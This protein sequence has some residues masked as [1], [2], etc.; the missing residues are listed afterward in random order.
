MDDIV[1]SAP[2]TTG[3]SPYVSNVVADPVGTTTATLTATRQ[4]FC[5]VFPT[6]HFR[7]R[8]KGT[9]TWTTRAAD[10]QRRYLNLT[11]LTPATTYE[12]DVS[13][14]ETYAHPFRIEFRTLP[15]APD[16]LVPRLLAINLEDVVRTSVTAVAEVA[17]KEADTSVHLLY[18]NL[19]SA[20]FSTRQSAPVTNTEARFPLSG[21][22][23]G[24]RYRLW[25]SLDQSLLTDT[26]TPA[27]KPDDVLSAEFTTIPPGVLGVAPRATGQTTA[28]LTVAIA[29]PNGQ[30]QTVYSQYRTASPLGST[31]QPSDWVDIG[32][33]PV[34]DG[35]TATVDITDLMSDTEYEARVSLDDTFPD[36]PVDATK[37]SPRFR[38]LPPGVDRLWVKEVGETTATI[39]IT[40]TLP[41]GQ[42]TLYLIYGPIDGDW[43]ASLEQDLQ[44][45]QGDLN[46]QAT[47]EI[48]LT[49]LVSG[50]EYEV[51]ISYDARLKNAVGT[52]VSSSQTRSAQRS[53]PK[54]GPGTSVKEEEEV[55][56]W[57]TGFATNP[58]PAVS[59][60]EV[61]DSGT[62][63]ITKTSA[64]ARVHVTNPDGTAE[65]HIRYSTDS[66][67]DDQNSTIFTDKAAP[68]TSATYFDFMLD[69]LTS[70]TTYYV[71]TSYDN[72]YPAST[73]TKST[74]FTT[75]PPI[76]TE[77]AAADIDQT[78]ATVTVTVDE[79]NDDSV[80]LHIKA[81]GLAWTTI[82]P[83]DANDPHTVVF[84][85]NAGT[86]TF[87]L[88]GL[89]AGTKYD[90]Y[91]SY[92]STAPSPLVELADLPPD[93][94]ATF[95]T[96]DATITEVAAADIDQTSA[97]VTVTVQT[98]TTKAV[99]LHYGKT[100]AL[101]STWSGPK[102]KVVALDTDTNTYTA[103]FALDMLTSGT[104]YTV[105]ASYESTPPASGTPLAPDQTDTFTTDPPSVDKV[106]VTD[107]TDTTAQVTVTIAAPNG[108]TQ[109][110]SVRYQTTPSGNW[111]TIQPDPTTDTATAVVDLTQLTANTQYR[112]EATLVGDSNQVVRFATFSTLSAGPSVSTVAMKDDSISQ[113]EA[114]AVVSIAKA[115][116]ASK[117]VR[118]HYRTISPEGLWETPT[119]ETTDTT[120][121]SVEID[122]AD[123]KSGTEYYVEA[124]LAGAFDEGVQST[125]FTTLP[126]K[127][128][129]VNVIDETPTTAKIR[130]AV[131]EPNGKTTLFLRYGSSGN[132]R[133]D[134]A[135]KVSSTEVGF[136]LIGL[137]PNSTYTVQ[138]S[139]DS[140]FPS[141]AT[142]TATANT[143]HL[144][145]PTVAVPT[146]T[147]TTAMVEMTVS[148]SSDQGGVVYHRHR[149]TPSGAWSTIRAA[150][151]TAGSATATLSGLTSDTEHTV[152]ASLSRSF[153]DNA[154]G[155]FTFTTDPPSVDRVEVTDKTETTAEIT[156]T[157][158]APNGDSQTVHLDYDTTSNTEQ[159]T[160]GS[161]A[162]PKSSSDG[163]ATID[164]SGLS[165]GTQYTV[166]ASLTQDFSGP[167]R[168][169]TFTTTS[170]DPDV[171]SVEVPDAT[172]T[173]ISATATITVANPGTVARTVHLRYQTADPVGAWI[174][175]QPSPAT[176]VAV[177]GTA[178]GELTPL[179]SG[180]QYKV[181]ASLDST[182]TSGVQSATFTTKAPIVSTV[183]VGGETRSTATVKV[184]VLN[185]NGQPVYLQYRTGNGDWIGRFANVDSEESSVDIGLSGL[186]SGT[187]YT[188]Q[189]SYD[190]T[191]ETGVQSAPFSTLA[192]PAPPPSRPNRPTSG[193][194]GTSSGGGTNQSPEFLDG[195]RAARS[196]EENTPAGV[197]VG[198]PIL[199]S[200]PDDDELTY[201]LGGVD[202]GRFDI[203][204]DSGQLL[205]RSALDYET[206]TIYNVTVAVSDGKDS[207]G[208]ENTG[209]D[210]SITVTILVTDQDESSPPSHPS[211]FGEGSRTVRSV[212]E[213]APAGVNV[214]NPILASDPDDD[215][216]TYSLGGVD[217][218]H[219]DIV[220]D[221]GQLLTR[222]ALDYE[223]KT[224]YNVTVSVHDGKDT[225]GGADTGR[226]DMI[227][228]SILVV[229]QEEPGTVTLSAPRPRVGTP[230]TAVLVDPDGG[231]TNL[232]WKWERSEDRTTWTAISGAATTSYTPTDDDEGPLPAGH[233]LLHRQAWRVQDGLRGTRR[234]GDR[235]HRGRLLR[236]RRHERACT[237]HQQPRLPRC[238]RR[239]RMRRPAVL[240]LPPA[241][242]V[243]NGRVAA[244]DPRRRTHQ[245]RWRLQVR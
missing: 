10:N 40:M 78:S 158:A 80:Y 52:S 39:A 105:Y 2:F 125:S 174:V 23:S 178:T 220:E 160:W 22:V 169:T 131:S 71:E 213:N 115:G 180:T 225:Q 210:D 182:F 95:T 176:T 47:I 129:M 59:S 86:Y 137:E 85:A 112:V 123:L 29:E 190:S 75:D 96:H 8:V 41:I 143:P 229:D 72:T 194:G 63:E 62:D 44:N 24:T 166:R 154:T 240:P 18:Q 148:P 219:F 94:T 222:S 77:V 145:A 243:G 173:R 236:C 226:D 133:N 239:Y 234:R 99:Q 45:L 35:D 163:E 142:A 197:D 215:E 135:T 151:L 6:Y 50:T 242:A 30:D 168:T 121:S 244:P 68:G 223:T 90:V 170:N 82:D 58:S 73:A 48:M 102:A 61:L 103:E 4:N 147:Q 221:S 235:R 49:G 230:L 116:T 93:Q 153:P 217:A 26:L 130:V 19:R 202:A 189:A 120:G 205:T 46:S 51:R 34:T 161:S 38:T 199:A 171:S 117:T 65:V 20:T 126:P 37:V 104:G 66:T 206:K 15:R 233:C 218:G 167:T 28:E 232:S 3:K 91:A 100:L 155:S 237:C 186:S 7:Y 25:V 88:T 27:T 139:F 76:I 118:L 149:E 200:D 127:A 212:V 216:M 60:V 165:P 204:E 57:K 87:D 92:G 241:Q 144:N 56:F 181:Q 106:E 157:I 136:D 111:T 245:R 198:G 134:F 214:G 79:P 55:P 192:A 32:H 1:T 184:E 69:N 83:D 146:K 113:T 53:V 97:T 203:V 177:P 9:E 209:R 132:W 98:S 54:N 33:Q 67:F 183:S 227:M 81:S 14:H 140:D 11:G 196:V 156:V 64:T 201:S 31:E 12:V 84:D 108:V 193:G 179:T 107:K 150:V 17:N 89:T 122:L 110:V 228:V 175:V 74:D 195:N 101:E 21:L 162:P 191:F 43:V 109:T 70:R 164:L 211:V 128:T 231:V 188:V 13:F 36:S 5:H 119:P 124:T 187:S 224:I 141:D 159:G 238:V 172:T 138:A 185:P 152:E 114:T 42:T 208:N 16:P 207:Y